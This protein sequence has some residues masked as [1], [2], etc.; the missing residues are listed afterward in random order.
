MCLNLEK[1]THMMTSV[2]Y[3]Q[4]LPLPA[5]ANDDQSRT[6]KRRAL[7]GSLCMLRSQ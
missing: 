2:H 7:P 4:A 6:D 3:N 5:T 1:N